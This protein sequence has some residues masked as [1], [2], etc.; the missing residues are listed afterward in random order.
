VPAECANSRTGTFVWGDESVATWVAAQAHNSFRIRAAGG[1]ALRTSAAANSA[2]GVA[3]NTGCDLP[4]GSGTWSCSSSRDLKENFEPAVDDDVLARLAALPI[5]RWNFKADETKAPHLGP[6]AEDFFEAFHLGDADKSIGVQ[7][8]SGVALAAAQALEKRTRH[9]A[10]EN[11]RLAGENREL[12]ER[13]E[14]IERVL[15]A[16]R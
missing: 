11:A 10:D 9:L 1:V 14:A 16:S 6:T 12:R 4:A 15:A 2:A 5:A 7:D 13:L 8:L 3:G